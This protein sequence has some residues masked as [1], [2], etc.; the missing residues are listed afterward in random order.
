VSRPL[1]GLA[2]GPQSLAWQTSSRAPSR[3]ATDECHRLSTPAEI[4]QRH[5]LSAEALTEGWRSATCEV[6]QARSW[7]KQAA[8]VL[9]GC[10]VKPSQEC[11]NAA[12]YCRSSLGWIST[13]TWAAWCGQVLT[14]GP[15]CWIHRLVPTPPGLFWIW[16]RCAPLA[17]TLPLLHQNLR[18]VQRRGAAAH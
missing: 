2:V 18:A 5:A 12:A 15:S 16:V 3:L 10:A 9:S 17:A 13:W 4:S 8:S 14:T 11:V 6:F 7:P 1:S